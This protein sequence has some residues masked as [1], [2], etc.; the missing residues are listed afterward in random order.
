MAYSTKQA[1][2]YIA[3]NAPSVNGAYGPKYHVIPPIG[4]MNDPNGLV[5]FRGKYHLFYQYNPYSEDP[6]AMHWGH[7]VSD[8]LI[9]YA[10]AGVA[11]APTEKDETSCFSGG[12]IAVDGALNLL[13][14]RHYEISDTKKEKVCL[15]K[16]LDG[17]EFLKKRH[18]VFNNDANHYKVTRRGVVERGQ[19]KID[20][21][22]I[23]LV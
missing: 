23:E 10:D 7:A 5:Y 6:G 19:I 14:T 9:S 16:S 4:W 12:G 13:Y 11:L 8:D 15:V 20:R 17:K 3:A 18:S 22:S 2:E 21:K 1:N